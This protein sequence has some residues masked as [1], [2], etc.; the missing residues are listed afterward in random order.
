[1]SER[2]IILC[3][4]PS[5]ASSSLASALDG[6]GD[7]EIVSD[8]PADDAIWYPDD[9]MDGFK[10]LSGY[11]H[12]HKPITAWERAWKHL[13]QTS[14]ERGGNVWFIEDDVAASATTWRYLAEKTLEVDADLS[15]VDVR[16]REDDP[17]WSHWSNGEGVFS[18]LTGSFN[19]ACRLS[20]RLVAVVLEFRR[21]HGRFLFQEVLFASLAAEHGFSF[22][23]WTKDSETKHLFRSFAFSP[24]IAEVASGICHPVKDP[25]VHRRICRPDF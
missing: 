18:N 25:A 1:M 19:P 12:C 11:S 21:C 22:L 6:L 9:A 10:F 17:D 13:D 7:V 2:F 20:S 3:R 5:C 16:P 15:S 24:S 14:G 23:D 8:S 4:T